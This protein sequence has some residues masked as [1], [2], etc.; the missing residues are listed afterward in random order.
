[1]AEWY[2]RNRNRPVGE[3]C[4]LAQAGASGFFPAPLS[5]PPPSIWTAPT[6]GLPGTHWFRFS[7]RLAERRQG[8]PGGLLLVG[9][10]GRG[11]GDSQ[12]P[13]PG[14]LQARL[15]GSARAPGG[16]G[17][18]GTMRRSTLGPV[19]AWQ[20]RTTQEKGHPLGSPPA[21]QY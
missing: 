18:A 1:M 10:E 11:V 15:L 19:K 12:P 14:E 8:W 17:G 13:L 2:P 21:L 9:Q 4:S 5:L 3:G 16:A 6:A 7:N 20:N